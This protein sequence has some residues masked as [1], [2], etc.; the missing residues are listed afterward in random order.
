MSRFVIPVRTHLV[1]VE[2]RGWLL[3]K[4]GIAVDE[5]GTDGNDE[6]TH[7]WL[8][9]SSA[10]LI[11]AFAASS[12]PRALSQVAGHS[13]PWAVICSLTWTIASLPAIPTKLRATG[14]SPRLMSRRPRGDST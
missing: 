1:Y 12:N 4:L 7:G 5:M 10:C 14:P 2:S 3:G 6:S 8:P 9:P 11:Q 13:R